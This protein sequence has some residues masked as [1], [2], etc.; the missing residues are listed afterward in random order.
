MGIP[1]TDL[2]TFKVEHS[3][4]ELIDRYPIS[5]SSSA[6]P[7]SERWRIPVRSAKARASSA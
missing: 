7:C 5:P 6:T 3:L 2:I 4:A 1:K